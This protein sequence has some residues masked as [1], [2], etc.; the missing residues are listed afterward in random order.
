[1]KYGIPIDRVDY[2]DITRAQ[3]A[4]DHI[5]EKKPAIPIINAEPRKGPWSGSN[6]LGYE[7][8]F[9]PSQTH[10]QTILKLDEW[11]FPEVWTVS[12][13]VRFDKELLSTQ[14]FDAIAT[15]QFG[16][17]GIVQSFDVDFV[18]G[19]IFSLPMNALN[20]LAIWKFDSLLPG[21]KPPG[22]HLS[23][24]IARGHIGKTRATYTFSV[25]TPDSGPITIFKIPAFAKSVQIVP[26]TPGA[27]ALYTDTHFEL[28]FA[29]NPAGAVVG[30]ILGTSIGNVGT[31]IPIPAFAQYWAVNDSG[32]GGKSINVIF[33]LFDE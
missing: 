18:D 20:V 28:L 22:V 11:G 2:E 33:S 1:M 14:V 8:P 7:I 17:G 25:T 21:V 16:S 24:I 31:K 6:Q 13:G 9:D 10:P 30:T 4:I 23:T 3:A 26:T 27:N 5:G 29:S 12:L 15:V 19:T 32:G